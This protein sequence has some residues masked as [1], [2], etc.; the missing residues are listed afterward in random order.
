MSPADTITEPEGSPS[1]GVVDAPLLSVEHLK[2]QFFTSRG[3]VKAV[4]DVSFTLRAGE[5]LGVLGE[6]GSGKS[7]T[8]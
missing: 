1:G 3:V 6:S 5:T 4:D 7:V 2:T 8:A